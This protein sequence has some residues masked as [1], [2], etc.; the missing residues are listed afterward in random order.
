MSSDTGA[1]ASGRKVTLV[2]P[3]S[4]CNLGPGL[5]TIGLALNIYTRMTFQILDEGHTSDS[6]LISLK[7]GIARRS[8][9]TDQGN[10]IYM[11]LSKIW[12]QDNAL[13]SRLRISVTSEIPLGCGLGSSSAAIIG[14]LWA[15]NVLEDRIPTASTLLAEG[16]ALEGH[17]ETLAA[18]LYGSVVVCAPS[19]ASDRKIVTQRLDWPETWHAIAVVPDYTLHTG[20]LRRALPAQ[21]SYPDAIFNLQ[22]VGLMVAAIAR[23]DEGAM[24]EALVDKLHERYREEYVPA[25]KKLRRELV[26]AP[27]IGCVLSGAG[28]SVIVFA[29]EKRK[30]EVIE[31]LNRWSEKEDKPHRVLDLQVA[32]EG[33]QEIEL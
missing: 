12:K 14:A 1:I 24:K 3:G 11:L 31:Q 16:C 30:A 28:S 9:P 22:R 27:I 17:P 20:K 21:V 23:A 29:K 19:S 2:V 4:T 33:M 15:A 5:D 13:L 10:L 8:Q 32:K 18:S 7:G 26:N 25:L 6:P